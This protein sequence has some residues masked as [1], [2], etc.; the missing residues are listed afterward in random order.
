VL[1][2][3]S[4]AVLS[5]E[6]VERISAYSAP[7]ILESEESVSEFE[8][9]ENQLVFLCVPNIFPTGDEESNCCFVFVKHYS[10]EDCSFPRNERE[11]IVA[12][13][14]L[15]CE[16][17][18]Y[19]SLKPS[20][21][22]IRMIGEDTRREMS[23]TRILDRALLASERVTHVDC[24][25]VEALS[26]SVQESVR[27]LL[28][29]SAA[30]KVDGTDET[31]AATVA[32]GHRC[33]VRCSL[34]FPPW[35]PNDL[36]SSISNPS[37]LRF[38]H[39]RSWL[40]DFGL[41]SE[42]DVVC[43]VISSGVSQCALGSVFWCPIRGSTGYAG[44]EKGQIAGSA[45][46]GLIA[47]LRVEKTVKAPQLSFHRTRSDSLMLSSSSRSLIMEE[48]GELIKTFCR[49][50]GLTVDRVGAAER[51]AERMEQASQALTTLKGKNSQLGAH[52]SS[53]VVDILR[54]WSPLLSI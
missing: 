20:A 48:E 26:A 15:V 44:G 21:L 31:G 13:V 24:A 37:P 38:E 33:S 51:A 23:N 12:A 50:I 34:L 14:A 35:P 47:L 3:A 22:T 19:S 18:W 41:S 36:H 39:L 25:S 9:E 1:T 42:Y 8:A 10:R 27:R 32:A 53:P 40:A 54:D 7:W 17:L 6:S 4:E 28:E 5:G 11:V 45:K 43:R 30:P 2:A 46:G 16:V 49:L 29:D 52:F